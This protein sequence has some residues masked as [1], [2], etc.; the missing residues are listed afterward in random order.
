MKILVFGGAGFLGSHVADYLSEHKHKVTIFDLKSSPYLRSNQEMI[1][2][3]MLN[4]DVVKRAVKDA[5][6]VYSFAGIADINEAK[7]N[8]Y[9]TIQTNIMGTANI[10][11]ACVANKVKRFIFASTVYVYSAV[12]SFYR[13]SKQACEL[14]IETY[15]EQFGLDFVILRYGSL[16]GPRADKNNW[17]SRILKDALTQKKIVRDGDGEELREYIHVF[18]AARLSV[19]ALDDEFKNQYVLI[20]GNQPMK[21]K[22]L[23]I[24]IKEMLN[25]EISIE[26]TN[27]DYDE[28]YEITPYNFRPK[29]AKRVVS[30]SYI[31]LGQGI[32]E[33]LN[34]IHDEKLFLKR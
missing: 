31:D 12:G 13:A 28:H 7:N 15:H 24:M 4:L 1:V 34:N 2:G 8:A 6:G 11:E 27:G 19:K 21:I 33:L 25:N 3:D 30:L 29:L 10:L 23:L 22:D 32:L 18:D 17:I 14:L 9:T 16:Y 5:D 20:T 26:F